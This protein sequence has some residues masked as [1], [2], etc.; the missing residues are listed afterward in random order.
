MFEWRFIENFPVGH[1]IER[2][3]AGEA[4]GLLLRAGMQRAKHFEQHF[5]ETRLQGRRAVAMN[6][7]HRS[8][9]IAGCGLVAR[10]HVVGIHR[11]Q[12]GG[13]IRVAPAHFGTGAMMLEVVKAQSEANAAIGVDNLAKFVKVSRLAIRGQAH[14]FKSV[15]G[16]A[17]SSRHCESWRCNTIPRE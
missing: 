11:A 6:F 2:H 16:T 8:R 3:A 10:C 15:A 7:L 14:D 12:L 13:F 4:D 9:G 5:F 1:A 17:V